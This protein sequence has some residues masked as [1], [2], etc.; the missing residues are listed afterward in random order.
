[1]EG[2]GVEFRHFYLLVDIQYMSFEI[3]FYIV[4]PIFLNSLRHKP[5]VNENKIV[6]EIFYILI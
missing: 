3:L 6:L 1:M 5:L 2:G 4:L